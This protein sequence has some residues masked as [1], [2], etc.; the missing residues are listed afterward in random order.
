M[1]T[2][3]I[4]VSPAVIENDKMGEI[5]KVLRG[6]G[7]IVYPTET[8][9]GLGANVFSDEAIQKV[10]RLKKRDPLKPL[11]VLI[12]DVDM[13]SRITSELPASFHQA[14][15]RLWPGPLTVILK[16]SSAV[17]KKLQGQAGTLGIRLPGYKWVRSLVRYL[18]FPITATSANVSGESAISSPIE[19][20][21]LFEGFVDLIVDGG[22]TEGLL[23]ST[24]VDLSGE[25]PILIRE[26]AIPSSQIKKYLPSLSISPL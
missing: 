16:A 1:K 11:S 7:I 9:Y 18:D 25:R 5:A 15:F 22:T 17:P 4:R 19:A 23:P 26:G 21:K 24:V 10:Y 8:F 2:R 3:I 20:K 14:V 6:G 12:S 13:L